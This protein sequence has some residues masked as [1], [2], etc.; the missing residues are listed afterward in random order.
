MSIFV[1]YLPRV[2]DVHPVE[3]VCSVLTVA[4]WTGDWQYNSVLSL[5]LAIAQKLAKIE[6]SILH[7]L[8][9]ST[10][11]SCF[12]MLQLRLYKVTYQ[13]S[14][15]LSLFFLQIHIGFIILFFT[16]H[17]LQ[18]FPYCLKLL[19]NRAYNCHD[20][21]FTVESSEQKLGIHFALEERASGLVLRKKDLTS[22]SRNVTHVRACDKNVKDKS[23]F[24]EVEKMKQQLLVCSPST[25]DFEVFFAPSKEK[26]EKKVVLD[27]KLLLLRTGQLTKY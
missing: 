8:E 21:L 19:V 3:N 9:S 11:S 14:S 22:T 16:I 18:Q 27:E 6:T 1:D 26:L 13:A 2:F 25:C 24:A 7:R 4:S 23:P 15:L 20:I 5:K 17:N 12:Q 10:P